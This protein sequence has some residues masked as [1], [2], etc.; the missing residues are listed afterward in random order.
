MPADRDLFEDAVTL[1][2][3]LSG[4]DG[5]H[6]SLT[7]TAN[8]RAVFTRDAVMAGIAGLMLDDSVITRA[9][10]R[11][12]ECLREMQGPEGQIA[13]NYVRRRGEPDRISF[14]SVVPRI[15]ATTWYLLGVALALRT[16]VVERTAFE[17]S[18]RSAVRLLDAVE[19]NGR[20]LIYIP[21]G[22]NWADE[23][24]YDGYILS[25]Q[26]LRSWALRALGAVLEQ[27]AWI[28]KAAR[29]AAAIAAGYW[30]E[31]RPQAYPL[32]AFSPVA[33]RG[34]FDL[35]A[36]TLLATSGIEARRAARALDWIADRFLGQAQLPPA[37]H[38]V[39]EEGDPDWPA[40]ERYHL[41]QF[42]N[43]PHEY[44]NGGIWP[45]WLGWLG[46]ALARAGRRQ[47]LARLREEVGRA[48]HSR[49]SFRFHE[50]LHGT[51]LTPGGTPDMAYTA[52]GMV[53]LR[54]A[55]SPAHERVF[56]T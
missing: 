38:P 37:F 33:Q 29:V 27:S 18:I 32:A 40:L 11:T 3:T 53:F 44:H 19:Y 30:P 50:F 51:T 42:R 56:G 8:Y 10:A 16:G 20:H 9:F 21:P 7:Q 4:A 23:Y 1:L 35:A 46:L 43:R 24:V 17:R 28:D 55:D 2:R 13:S 39:I 48:L 52:T 54:L 26:V 36:C 49:S 45:V 25:D 12:L 15:D 6:A 31:G 14:G 34:V 22:G 41:Y 5:I 47:A